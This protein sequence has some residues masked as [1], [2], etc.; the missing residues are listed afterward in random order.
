MPR[1]DLGLVVHTFNVDPEAK[2]IAQLAS[3]SPR[4]RRLDSEGSTKVA[5]SKLHKTHL[6][7]AMVFQ[8]CTSEEEKWRDKMLCGLQ[9][10]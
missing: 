9:K 5:G 7:P 4:N 3:V 8:Y 2:P 1:L 6:A 10:P